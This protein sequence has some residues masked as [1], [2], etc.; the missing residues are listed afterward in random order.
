MSEIEVRR[1]DVE[2]FLSRFTVRLTDAEGSSEHVVTLSGSDW[3][4]LRRGYRSPEELI[5]SSFA[6]LL[7]REPRTSILDSFDVSQI[8]TFFPEFERE[9]VRRPD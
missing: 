5:R 4:R 2:Q 8:S 6:F 9:I 1:A 7:E 3:E